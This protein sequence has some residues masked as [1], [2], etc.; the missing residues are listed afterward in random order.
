MWEFVSMQL[1]GSGGS[2][3]EMMMLCF[4]PSAQ[5]NTCFLRVLSLQLKT[6]SVWKNLLE[7]SSSICFSEENIQDLESQP[8]W[9]PLITEAQKAVKPLSAFVSWAEQTQFSQPGISSCSW[10]FISHG[11]SEGIAG[12]HE[13]PSS[14][15]FITI[16]FVLH[17]KCWVRA[18]G[19][20]S[21][22]VGVSGQSDE[23]GAGT[24]SASSCVLRSW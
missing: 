19:K 1:W 13:F 15:V 23:T 10:C 14:G 22:S 17:S 3:T 12:I 16:L 20:L 7:D 9:I 5:W 24:S 18:P 2:G 11:F 21:C 6:N 8:L 4:V